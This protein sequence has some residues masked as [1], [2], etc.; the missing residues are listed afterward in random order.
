MRA[1][2]RVFQP[3]TPPQSDCPRPKGLD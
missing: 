3:R 2:P 1:V